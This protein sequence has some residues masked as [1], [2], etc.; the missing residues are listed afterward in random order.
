MLKRFCLIAGLATVLACNS[1]RTLST[2]TALNQLSKAE[3]KDGWQLLFDG[4]SKKGWHIFNNRSDG[5]A[6]KTD[7]GAVYLDP[8]AKGP[9]GAGGGDLVT[10]E[11]FS[12][13]HLK[14]EWKLAP[15]GNS[16]IMF[17]SQ[18]G[19]QYGAS[20]LT[21][22]EMQIIDNDAHADAKHEKHRAGDLYD[23]IAAVPQ[24]VRPIGQW[25]EVEILYNNGQLRLF[26]NGANVVSTVI[27]DDN[28]Q[29]LVNNSKFKTW[30]DFARFSSGKIALQDHGDKV[31]FRNIRIKKL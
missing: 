15:G 22:P 19:E 21:G 9:K 17:L 8:A 7:S 2:A 12:N 16:G 10:D 23:I 14:L 4:S 13:F 25:N 26:Q 6:W 3:A 28:W 5:S 30:K 1:T 11:A 27:G 31:W 18:E 24:N 20:Y 29:A